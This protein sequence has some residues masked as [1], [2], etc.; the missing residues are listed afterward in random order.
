MNQFNALH[1]DEPTD[2]PIY[3]NIQTTE[4]HFKSCNAPRTVVA[5]IMGKLNHHYINGGDVEV[6]P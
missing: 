4:D 1:G 6:R 3:W 5:A 2:P